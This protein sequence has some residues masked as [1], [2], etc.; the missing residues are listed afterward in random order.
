MAST[1]TYFFK[2]RFLLLVFIL[3]NAPL[4]GS[5]CDHQQE[6]MAIDETD[7][8][9][10]VTAYLAA[11]QHHAGTPYSNW[12]VM[13]VED[14]DWSAM[15]HLI[16]FALNIDPSG[17]PGMSLNPEYRMNFNSDRLEVIVPAA[18][19]ND[20]KILFSVGGAGNYEGFSSAIR[21]ENRQQFIS[22]ITDLIQNY[23]FDGVDLD[24][25]PIYPS[26]HT[27]FRSF[28][29]DLYYKFSGIQTRLGNRP[30]ITIAALKGVE[31][32]NLYASVQQYADQINI[33]T[34]DMAQPWEGWQAW[35]HTALFSNGVNFKSTGG[36]MPSV[37]EKVEEALA[38]GIER[39]KIGIGL[40]FYGYIWHSIHRLEIWESW[41]R[42]DLSII[43]R[44]GGVPYYELRER[45]NLSQA[46]WDETAQTSYLNVPE[47]KTFV[48][49]D[50]KRSLTK[51]VE[52]AVEEKL[53]GIMIWELGGGFIRDETT[54]GKNPLLDAVKKAI[55]Q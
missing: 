33:M 22:T 41:P 21:P 30:L 11:W 45:F 9:F 2:R 52:F 25:E 6:L 26:D 44:R 12:G 34:Y 15:T 49:F 17:K 53:G 3:I 43:E 10:W 8:T 20:T 50:N 27:N 16:Y 7:H 19:R 55:G 40:D 35:H 36:Q 46:S 14:I 39:R 24:M 48:S 38:A 13:T 4:F 28:V 42:E 31:V 18:H 51:K 1:N 32:S 54:E 23:G 5:A 47:P 37:Q 29:R